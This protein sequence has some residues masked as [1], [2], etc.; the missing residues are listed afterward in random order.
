MVQNTKVKFVSIWFV[1][2]YNK[3]HH[4]SINP[5]LKYVKLEKSGQW[6]QQFEPFTLLDPKPLLPVYQAR[7][8]CT[9]I[10]SDKALYQ[11]LWQTIISHILKIGNHQF[12]KMETEQVHLINSTG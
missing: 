10:E 1:E 6:W 11:C 7:P 9:S 5:L 4:F 8:A 3:R 2:I 12:R